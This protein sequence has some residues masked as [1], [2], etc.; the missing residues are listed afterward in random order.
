MMATPLETPSGGNRLRHRRYRCARILGRE[1]GGYNTPRG[2]RSP[3]LLRRLELPAFALF[4]GTAPKADQETPLM[5]SPY[6]DRPLLPL[7]VALPQM[8]ETI[9]AELRTAQPAAQCQLRH[10]AELM[11]ELLWSIPATSA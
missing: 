9:E 10:R 1:C 7:A 6:L 4:V 2:G 3:R 5:T 8:L 11:R